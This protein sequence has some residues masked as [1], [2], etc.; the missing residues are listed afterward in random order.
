[1]ILFYDLFKRYNEPYIILKLKSKFENEYLKDISIFPR[2]INFNFFQF[3]ND[4]FIINLSL[5]N[6]KINNQYTIEL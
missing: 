4:D 6:A 1:M 5:A 2:K 3:L